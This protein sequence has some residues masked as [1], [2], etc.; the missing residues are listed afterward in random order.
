MKKYNYPFFTLLVVALAWFTFSG[1]QT[2]TY[3]VFLDGSLAHREN[4]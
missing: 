4:R 3:G 1:C 2:S